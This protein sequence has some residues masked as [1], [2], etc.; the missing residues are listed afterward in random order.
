MREGQ[1]DLGVRP[2]AGSCRRAASRG[3][4]SSHPQ[5]PPKVVVGSW[6]CRGR[7]VMRPGCGFRLGPSSGL[8]EV[9][10]SF[11]L[12][13]RR[14]GVR[15]ACQFVQS[16]VVRGSAGR[17]PAKE[18]VTAV[19]SAARSAARRQPG[20]EGQ[21]SRDAGFPASW[22]CGSRQFAGRPGG[23]ARGDERDSPAGSSSAGGSGVAGACRT[24]PGP[25]GVR[26][27][28]G[29]GEARK[30][31]G[32]SG[33][34][35]APGGQGGSGIVSEDPD[36]AAAGNDAVGLAEVTDLTDVAELDADVRSR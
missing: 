14:R 32:R 30:A 34:G 3:S 35:S 10:S 13:I 12:M 19:A 27:S 1:A 6:S 5:T 17:R 2:I 36:L 25:G 21:G 8:H 18:G 23:H 7:G 4:G 11:P 29:R 31:A 20:P 24:P 9:G 26:N 33:N 16:G 15:V 28:G 22:I